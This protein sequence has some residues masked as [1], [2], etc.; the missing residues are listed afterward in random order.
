MT[1]REFGGYIK[2]A[3]GDFDAEWARMEREDAALEGKAQQL[4][5]AGRQAGI[6]AGQ[7]LQGTMS[8]GQ[9]TSVGAGTRV[10]PVAAKP[11]A[12]AMPK[13]AAPTMT[14]RVSRSAF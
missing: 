14:K 7:P 12:L 11:A 10:P 4:Q 1:P 3:M 9:V 8:R 6:P 13:P 2:R 5:A